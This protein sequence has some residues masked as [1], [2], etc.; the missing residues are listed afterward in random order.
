MVGL[1]L[2]RPPKKL[3][4]PPRA[5]ICR[6]SSCAVPEAAATMMTSAPRP[7]V[8]LRTVSTVS[9]ASAPMASSGATRAAA[10]SSRCWL[11]SMRNTRAAPRALASRTCMQP[12]GPAP[13]T[14]TVSPSPTL[15]CSWPLM[16]QA[17]GSATDASANDRP[18]GTRLTP[19]TASTL[20]GTRMSSAKPPSYW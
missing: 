5:A 4:R 12:I 14:A 15:A 9:V 11:S 8:S 18:S 10:I 13:T 7:S 16:T 20:A 1:S 3:T 19:S 2:G 6:P 17:S